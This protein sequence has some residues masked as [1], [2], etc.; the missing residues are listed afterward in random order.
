[1]TAVAN[2][3]LKQK[4]LVEAKGNRGT[5]DTINGYDRHEGSRFLA[6]QVTSCGARSGRGR[7]NW[8]ARRTCLVPPERGAISPIT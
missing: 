5:G 4:L 8:A 3:D 1:V 2:G 6:D 7:K